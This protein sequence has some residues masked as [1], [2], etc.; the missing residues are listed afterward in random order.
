MR[1]ALVYNL[2]YGLH[3]YE[4]EFDSQ[5]TIDVL[6]HALSSYYEVTL[7]E[8][9]QDFE[10]FLH[11]LLAAKPEIIFNVAE[12]FVGSAREAFY[13]A[14]YDQL[15]LRFCGPDATNLI[16][17]QNKLLAKNLLSL[18]HLPVTKGFA[19]IGDLVDDKQIVECK[20]PLI[21]KLNSEGSGIGLSEQSIVK[22]LVSLR[23]QV[24][25]IWETY[26]KPILIEEYIEGKDMSMAYIE[27]FGAMGPC[28]VICTDQHKIYDYEYKTTKDKLVDIRVA[29]DLSRETKQELKIIVEKIAKTLGIRGYAKVDFRIKPNGEVYILE[30]NG[31]VSFHP[32]GEF[33]V[34]VE[35]EGYTMR[36]I[37]H[38]IVE[39]ANQEGYPRLAN[40]GGDMLVE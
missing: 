11:N 1:V 7:V 24:K 18:A 22:D 28:Q 14:L 13:P 9:T 5:L 19:V 26:Q 27:G 35:S 15:H 33:M 16:I 32:K 12:G 31:Q 30:V 39:Y 37:T 36:D 4:V 3:E 34:C 40:L 17:S 10:E 20:F 6:T 8:S 29:E 2:N 38:H 25:T 23:E 21:V